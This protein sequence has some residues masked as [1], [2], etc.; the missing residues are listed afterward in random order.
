MALSPSPLTSRTI[1][2]P[3][4]SQLLSGSMSI[5]KEVR[6]Q[7]RQKQVVNVILAVIVVFQ[8]INLPGAILMHS[9][10]SIGTVVLGLVLCA[11]AMIFNF[12]G[13]VIIVSLLLIAVVDLGC[14]LMLLTT[15][16]GLDASDLP[17]FDVL[18]VSEI[19]AV[20]LISPMSVFPVALS[21]IVFIIADLLFQ[22]RT[23]Q[24][25]MVLKSDMAYNAIAQ[26][27]SLQI[28]VAVVSFVWVR[29]ALFALSRADRAEEIAEIR[30]KEAE[31]QKI[32]DEGVQHLSQVLTQAANGDRTVRANMGQDNILWRVGNSLNLLLTRTGRMGVLEQ[33]N[34]H[35]RQ[36]VVRVTELWHVSEVMSRH[37]V[38]NSG[39]LNKKDKNERSV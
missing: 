13:R 31:R 25:D 38:G 39:P 1:T 7:M 29:N 10:I 34:R 11:I 27:I 35:L 28:V 15:P 2:S 14:G 17:I 8:L 5:R 19:I 24:L 9:A 30:R 36:E 6:D 26:P 16:M 37:T 22:P 20:S 21:N 18:I 33:E 23:M 12:Q 32:L 4:K 3:A